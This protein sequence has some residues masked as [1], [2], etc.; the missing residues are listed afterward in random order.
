MAWQCFHRFNQQFI[1]PFA[2]PSTSHNNKPTQSAPS[3]PVLSAMFAASDNPFDAASYPNSGASNHITVD[4]AN[5]GNATP[6]T[7][8]KQIF[9]ASGLQ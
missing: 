7:G 3:S 6:Y 4:A 8:S 2:Q 5:L 1:S 9:L